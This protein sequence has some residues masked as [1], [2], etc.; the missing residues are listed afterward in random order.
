MMTCT[1]CHEPLDAHQPDCHSALQARAQLRSDA[2]RGMDWTPAEIRLVGDVLVIRRGDRLIPLTLRPGQAK[3][4][5][6]AM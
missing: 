2:R 1:D 6:E 4:V 3:A 5:R